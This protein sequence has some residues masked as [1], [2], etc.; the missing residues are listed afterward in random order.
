MKRLCLYFLV[1]FIAP[2]V[3][4][5]RECFSQTEDWRNIKTGRVIPDESYSDQPYILNTD[6][7]AWL[8]VLTT[9]TG[10]EGSSGQHLIAQ[11]SWD[12][13][14]TWVDRV[15][16]E[17]VDGPE[18]SY[19]VLLKAPGGRIFVFYNYNTDNARWV[20]GDPAYYKDGKVKRVDTQGYYVFKYSDDNG[21][22]W[23]A[24]RCPVP[25]RLFDI[26]KR[27]PYKGAIRYFWNVGKPFIFQEKVYVPLHKVGGFGAGFIT[28]SE[29][30]LLCSDNLLTVN[31]PARAFWSTL[32]EGETGLRAPTGGG[33]VSEEQS[34]VVL[35]DG[36]FFCVYRTID[37]Y[38]AFSYSRDR[39]HTW[40]A[41]QY[42]RFAG[43]RL[44]KH[45]RAANF[46]WKCENGKYLYWFHNHGGR[47]IGENPHRTS[48]AYDDRNPAWVCGGE[49]IDSPI[50]KVI[51]WSEPEILLYDEDPV[52]RI[53]YPDLIEDKGNYYI[54]ETQKDIARVHLIDKTLLE[55]LWHQ[56][57]TSSRCD[58]NIL[59][60][61]ENK[62]DKNTV[63]AV[64]PGLPALYVV[65]R[66][67]VEQPGAH[68]NNGFTIEFSL[69]TGK[70]LPGQNLLN[71]TDGSGKGWKIRM[72]E[73]RTVELI[74]N[75]G[76]T[77]A[78]WESTPGILSTDKDHYV[79]IIVDGGPNIICFVIDGVL[80][81]GGNYRQFGWG[82][83]SPYFKSVNAA[84]N[85]NILGDKIERLTIYGEALTV[86]EAVGN[87]R[88]YAKSRL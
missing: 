29:G 79:S 81:D 30:V 65:D 42:M 80:D 68:L 10:H 67:K 27:N 21:K 57:I 13:G 40:D 31:D 56:F 63:T 70:W 11:R 44:M 41:P 23:S 52:I 73:N 88:H 82:R 84:K 71:A 1:V 7:G 43:G 83:F 49:E 39:G 24:K 38:P 12:K 2:I 22:T 3:S 18:A 53:S 58:K 74:M 37:G 55:G 4:P 5:W 62:A 45:P 87:F 35:S 77:E 75:D 32:P 33:P 47:L 34:M 28:S 76:Q 9:G 54:S 60:D 19:S 26:D 8:S 15:A 85:I 61:W 17:P 46:V 59:L 6:D 64:A 72:G 25:V 48:I 66:K 78:V 16:I 20:K 86:S 36:S 51:R 14:K 69:K 50:G